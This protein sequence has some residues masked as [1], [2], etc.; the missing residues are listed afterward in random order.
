MHVYAVQERPNQ[1]KMVIY[2]DIKIT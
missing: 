1:S 2:F